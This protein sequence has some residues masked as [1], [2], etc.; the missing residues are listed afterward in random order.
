MGNIKMD[1]GIIFDQ[2][3]L[4]IFYLKISMKSNLFIM[5]HK[6]GTKDSKDALPKSLTFGNRL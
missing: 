1:R 2:A 6:I 4:V 3:S 5:Q